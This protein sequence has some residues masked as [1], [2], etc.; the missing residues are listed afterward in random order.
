MRCHRRARDAVTRRAPPLRQPF[1]RRARGAT[2]G[3]TDR[4]SS[5]SAERGA[6]RTR[7]RPAWLGKHL[8]VDVVPKIEISAV[9]PHRPSRRQAGDAPPQRRAGA[10]SIS[11]AHD[12]SRRSDSGWRRSAGSN[13]STLS[14]AVVARRLDVELVAIG[15]VELAH[16]PPHACGLHE[17]W[18]TC[19]V[20]LLAPLPHDRVRSPYRGARMVGRVLGHGVAGGSDS[21]ALGHLDGCGAGRRARDERRRVA[22]TYQS[23]GPSY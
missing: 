3:G 4:A 19:A 21:L 14:G 11:A 13:R 6:D 18:R 9:E 22:P 8:P 17:T 15:T 10:G 7:S 23:V 2:A 12:R 16:R 1:P 5:P 20:M